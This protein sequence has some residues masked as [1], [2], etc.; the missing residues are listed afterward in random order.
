LKGLKQETAEAAVLTSPRLWI[1][2]TETMQLS[3]GGGA[4]SV[5]NATTSLT[6]HKPCAYFKV[7]NLNKINYTTQKLCY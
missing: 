6:V 7:I 2:S 1:N 4:E 5:N 3:S